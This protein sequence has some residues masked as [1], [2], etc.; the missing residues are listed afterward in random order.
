MLDTLL[1]GAILWDMSWF[2]RFQR[3]LFPR[4]WPIC[5]FP[6]PAWLQVHDPKKFWAR[7]RDMPPIWG[8][9]VKYPLSTKHN[10][11]GTATGISP[12]MGGPHSPETLTPYRT[13]DPPTSTTLCPYCNQACNRH[14][15][16]L[17]HLQFHYRMV[18]V[19][20]ICAGCWSSSWW[21]IKSHVKACAQQRL[22]IAVHRV[23][24]GEPLWQSSDNRLKALQKLNQQ[25]Q[26]LNFQS[27]QT[28]LMT[29]Q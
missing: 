21:M 23:S 16:L 7:S 5:D 11:G 3:S 20:P 8:V 13:F 18:L 9:Y 22:S 19:C 17:N 6:Y 15:Q 26:H 24:P 12:K 4:V 1:H 28:H 29:P 14:D 25:L 2:I 10:K 27:G